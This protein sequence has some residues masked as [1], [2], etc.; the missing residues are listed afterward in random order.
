MSPFSAISN[1]NSAMRT[2][3]VKG[4][5]TMTQIMYERWHRSNRHIPQVDMKDIFEENPNF[6]KGKKSCPEN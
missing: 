3:E 6:N 5:L 1:E 2:D 4:G